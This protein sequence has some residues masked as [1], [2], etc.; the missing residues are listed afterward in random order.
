MKLGSHSKFLRLLKIA[1][2]KKTLLIISAVLAVIG[3]AF[4]L[5]PY[6]IIYIVM[7]RLLNPDFGSQDFLYVQ[8]LAL[9]AAGV[10]VLR[11]VIMTA[12]FMLSHVA[13]F[14]ILYGLRTALVEHLGKL[15]MGFFNANQTGKIKKILYE[16]VE[17]IEQFIAHHIPDLVSGMMLPVMIIIYLF[18]VDWHMALVALLP[19]P[20]AFFLQQKAFDRDGQE[21]RR[22]QYHNALENMNGTIVEYIRGM[23]VVK[24]FSQTVQSFTRLKEAVYAYRHFIEEVTRNMAPAWAMFIVITSSGQFF[25]LPFGLWFYIKDIISLPTLFLFLMLGS[26]YMTPLFKL[27][28]LGGQLGHILEGI[29][30]MDGILNIPEISDPLI[31]KHPRNATIQFKN[32]SFA[33]GDKNVLKNISFTIGEGTVTALVGP[34]G[35]GKTT[36]AQLLLRMWDIR[37]GEILLGGVNI[38]EIPH[39]ELMGNIGFVFQNGF[40][41]SDTVYENIRMGMENVSREDIES[42]ARASQCHDFIEKL[43]KGLDTLIGEGGEVHLSGGEKQR[44]SMARIILKNAPIVILDEATAY[45]DAENETRIQAAFSEIMRDKTVIVIAHRLSTITDADD[46]IVIKNGQIVEQGRHKALLD[47]ENVYHAMWQAHTVAKEWTLSL[48]GGESC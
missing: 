21:D 42:A 36:I 16:D 12:A 45:A 3:S 1:G 43:P 29:T 8:N 6:I 23:P 2:T 15:P 46:I 18:C 31:P 9:I 24:I 28:M 33:Y 40:I 44:I 14:K 25:I 32:V 35:A 37:E 11:Y 4:S 47:N 5:L 13:A 7:V 26:G 38:K 41:F 17:E 22:K 27:A 48:Q 39:D 10:V 19:L 20:L 30:R 34:S